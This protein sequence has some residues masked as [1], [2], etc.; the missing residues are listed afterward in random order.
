[1]EKIS[2]WIKICSVCALVSAVLI[3]VVPEGRLKNTYKIICALIM[4]FT[5]FSFFSS[6]RTFDLSCLD[7]TDAEISISEKNEEILVDEGERIINNIIENKLYEGGIEVE[8][9]TEMSM[10]DDTLNY[11]CIYLYGRFSKSDKKKAKEMIYNLIKEEC[12]V[13]FVNNNE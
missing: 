1:M 5:L 11:N 8:C 9:R 6:E 13:I 4:L 12:E 2:L 7:N 3:T 10:I